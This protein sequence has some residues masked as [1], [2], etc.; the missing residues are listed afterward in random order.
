[1]GRGEE[2][3]RE[4]REGG[5]GEREGEERGRERRERGRG[6]QSEEQS[7][8]GGRMTHSADRKSVRLTWGDLIFIVT[9]CGGWF[10]E[11]LAKST[12]IFWL[13]A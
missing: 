4:R 10:R 7:G 12:C 11:G 13:A 5:R 2:R 1:M 6:M 3:G 9:G 8:G